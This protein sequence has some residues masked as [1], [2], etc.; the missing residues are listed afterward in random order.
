MCLA[1]LERISE[2][3]FYEDPTDRVA[4]YRGLIA[5]A[6]RAR[7]IHVKRHDS[8]HQREDDIM[9]TENST[10]AGMNENASIEEGRYSDKTATPGTD[11]GS[12]DTIDPTAEKLLRRKIDLRV[13]PI[14]FIVYALSFLDRINISNAR[15]QGLTE[16]LEL[17]G[18]RYNIAL[19][20]YFIPYILFEVPS[21]MI[22]KRMRPSWYISSLMFG[23]GIVN[24]SMGFVK[25]YAQLV[26]LRVLLSIL[27]AGVL[28]GII[29]VTSLYYKRH[30]LQLRLSSFFCSTIIA[31][32]LGGVS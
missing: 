31:S 13:Y 10:V 26:I 3:V 21:N 32:A 24:M 14:L 2:E 16:D 23:W 6:G 25:T 15:I 1:C 17:Y 22:I 27:E 20:V 9:A 18:N 19:V 7:T 29:Y 5:V 8:H 12:L 28:P 30:E 11:A 4:T